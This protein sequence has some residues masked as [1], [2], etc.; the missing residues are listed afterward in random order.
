MQFRALFKSRSSCYVAAV[1]VWNEFQILNIPWD[2]AYWNANTNK[3]V[4]LK[5]KI[6]TAVRR[7]NHPHTR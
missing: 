3:F 2:E 1:V 4:E 7:M 5:K 6:E